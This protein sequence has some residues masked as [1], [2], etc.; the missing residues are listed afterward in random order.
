[1]KCLNTTSILPEQDPPP[2]SVYIRTQ[3]LYKGPTH[4]LFK[5]AMSRLVDDF[6]T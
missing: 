3:C 2:P 4:L 1:M 5:G 6:T